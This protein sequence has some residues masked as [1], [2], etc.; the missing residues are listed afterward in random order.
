MNKSQWLDAFKELKEAGQDHFTLT[1]SCL[2]VESIP[3]EELKS[4]GGI[5]IADTKSYKET[6]QDGRPIWVRVLMTGAGY[7]DDE[8]GEDIPGWVSPG[9]II[10]VG[11]ASCQWFSEFGNLEGYDTQTIG[12][13]RE[14]EI[15]LQFKG[16]EGYKK[17]FGILNRRG[18][19]E[20]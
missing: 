20:D 17:A 16:E 4:K 19:S 13:T 14:E 6:L 15:K 12:I 11:Q 9:D 2:L 7:Y 10:L 5:I 18:K 8:T 3:K 1:G